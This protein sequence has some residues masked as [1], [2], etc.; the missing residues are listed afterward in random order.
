MVAMV[1]KFSRQNRNLRLNQARE[2]QNIRFRRSQAFRKGQTANRQG[3]LISRRIAL[4]PLVRPPNVL[5]LSR[6]RPSCAG[7]T[8][9]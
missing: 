1:M 5:S 2:L 6:S 4:A 9:T 3:I 8:D 7:Q